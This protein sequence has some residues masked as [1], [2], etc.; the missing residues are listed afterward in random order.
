MPLKEI[1]ASQ[2]RWARK[3][4]PGHTGRC[5]PGLDAN[6]IIPMASD[7]RVQFEGGSGG[8]LGKPGRPGKMSSLR[9]SSALTYNFFAPWLGH[10]LRPLAAAI[11][12]R[13]ED[14]T[15]RFER[16]FRHGLSSIPPNLDVTLDNDQSRPLAIECKFSEPYG[17]KKDHPPLDE[18]YFVGGRLRWAEQGLPRCQALAAAVGRTIEFRRLG[19]GQLLKHI[20]GLAWSTKQTPRLVCLWFDTRCDEA[21]EH[22][23]ELGRFARDIDPIVEFTARSYQEAFAKLRGGFE[24]VPRYFDYLE[25]RYFAA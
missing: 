18:K 10:D 23:A 6:L 20:L 15:L 21:D 1:L 5:A 24:P 3:R 14:G 7:V 13:V 19:I 4:W 12:H 8:E 2:D 25:T 17:P 9:S 16:Q 22:R 11:E